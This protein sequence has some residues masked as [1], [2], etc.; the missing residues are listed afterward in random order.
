[1]KKAIMMIKKIAFFL[2]SVLLS[3]SPLFADPGTVFTYQGRLADGT[4]AIE[5]NVDLQFTLWDAVTSGSQV[6]TTITLLNTAYPGGIVQVDLDF[7][8]DSFNGDPRWL[9]IEL[10]NPASSSFVALNPR[11]EVLPTPYSI[12]AQQANNVLNDAVNDADANPNNELNNTL[13]LN[14]SILELND[15]GGTLSADL[16]SIQAAS[17][18]PIST[19]PFTINNPG[20]YYV[21]QNLTG[22]AAQNGITVN[23]TSDVTI[24]LNGFS[25]IGVPGS[26]AGIQFP[27]GASS[28]A[29]HNGTVRSWGGT[30][31][32]ANATT[33]D[34][35]FQNIRAIGNGSIGIRA[36]SGSL[37]KNCIAS[38][39]GGDGINAGSNNVFDNCVANSNTGSADGIDCSDGNVIKGCVANFNAE[40]GI[41][42]NAR[43]TIVNCTARGNTILGISAGFNCNVSGCTME[44]NGLGGMTAGLAN[45]VIDC[46][47]S[48]NGDNA[49]DGG[50]EEYGFLLSSDCKIRNCIA[51][52]N[53]SAFVPYT[54]PS[55][56]AGI[57]SSSAD[58]VVEGNQL[59]DNVHGIHI[60]GGG[61][62]LV[63]KN[64]AS[65]N[66]NNYTF[67][68]GV[69]HGPLVTVGAGDMSGTTNS[70][71]PQANFS[72]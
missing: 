17:R 64:T 71:H 21:T 19:L 48:N 63:V 20:S 68:G 31:V 43:N 42:A 26:L 30:G 37:F 69:R 15:A 59:T 28:M 65:G 44:E 54:G 7:E 46:V 33:V 38:G 62:N 23:A 52:G 24:D 40:T 1:M 14:G 3:H 35:I 41:E 29:V 50:V 53:G 55:G 25:L 49:D 16:T 72:Y 51:D 6:G 47:A 5:T 22:V 27:A 8:E 60:T 67:S 58:V 34:S 9:Q 61:T 57:Y 36:G 2:I 13:N 56:G 45:L 10:A 18:I 4:T 39:N 70:N 32:S 11:T 66:T 12:F